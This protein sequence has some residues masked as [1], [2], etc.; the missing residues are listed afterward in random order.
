MYG[1]RDS[2]IQ[3]TDDI[4]NIKQQSETIFKVVITREDWIG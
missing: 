2:H 1:D 4:E 3:E